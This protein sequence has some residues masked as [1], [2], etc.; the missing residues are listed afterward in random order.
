MSKQPKTRYNK[1][2]VH[3]FAILAE[4]VRIK[5]ILKCMNYNN[6]SNDVGLFLRSSAETTNDTAPHICMIQSRLTINKLITL[7]LHECPINLST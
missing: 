4:K 6:I 7:V 3:M 5:I 1:K 2:Q